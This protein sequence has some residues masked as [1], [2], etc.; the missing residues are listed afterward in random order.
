MQKQLDDAAEAAA[1]TEA[2]KQ[3]E[4]EQR[5]GSRACEYFS[6]SRARARELLPPLPAAPVPMSLV[7]PTVGNVAQGW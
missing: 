6:L 1:K 5:V 3:A 7:A 4:E 2:E